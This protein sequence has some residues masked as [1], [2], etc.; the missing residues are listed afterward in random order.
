M[1]TSTEEHDFVEK[2]T[3]D[4][5]YSI[6]TSLLKDPVL[7]DCCGQHYCAGCLNNWLQEQSTCPHCR[8]QCFKHMK[9]LPKKRQIKA[10]K[11]YC[12]NRSKGC[13]KISTVGEC[14]THL[15][16]CLFVE[17]PCTNKCGTKM[18]QKELQNHTANE[19]LKRTVKCNYCSKKMACIKTLYQDT[20]V[21]SVHHSH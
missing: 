18:K 2:L 21:A 14:S 19:C 10:L 7:T 15:E 1:A 13:V 3:D 9:Y 11:T 12:P 17:V 5:M 6:C 4:N 8:D 16:T 20:I